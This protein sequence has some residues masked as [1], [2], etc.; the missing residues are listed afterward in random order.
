MIVTVVITPSAPVQLQQRRVGAAPH[1][2]TLRREQPLFA[3]RGNVRAN[4]RGGA[5]GDGDHAA[6]TVAAAL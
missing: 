3:A 5:A 6:G 4:G 1:T 2:A